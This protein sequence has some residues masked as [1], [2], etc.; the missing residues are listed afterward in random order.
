MLRKLVFAVLI[1][2]VGSITL[3]AVR[4]RG[5]TVERRAYS[6]PKLV[7]VIVIDQFRYDYL[8]RFRPEFV[9]G[10]F[11]RLLNGGANFI[12]CRYDDASTVTC[13]GH[14]ALFSGAY[15]DLNGIIANNWYD[16]VLHRSV[17]CATDLGT[18]LVGG[19]DVQ[20][21]VPAGA[22]PKNLMGT[23]LGDEMRMASDFKSKVV[24]ISLKDRSA[25]MPGGHTANAAYWYDAGSGHFV[26]STYYMPKLPAWVKTFN[27]HPPVASYCGKDWK[28]LPEN[29]IASGEVFKRFTPNQAERCPDTRFLNWL[30]QTPYM[31]ALEL[32]FAEDAI[33]N[34]HLGAGPATDL[35][36]ISISENDVIGHAYGPYSAQVAD[37]TLWTDR[38][39]AQFFQMVDQTVG[40]NNV[41]IVLSADHG[42][43][44]NPDFIVK[45]RL[46]QG[47]VDLADLHRE[48]ERALDARFGQDHWIESEDEFYLYLSRD[49]MAR[50]HVSAEAVEAAAASA[51]SQVDGV[52]AAFTRAQLMSSQVPP[53][54]LARKVLHSFNPQRSGDVFLVL[55][56]FSVAV[57]PG[58][59]TTHGTPWSYDAQVPLIFWGNAFTPGIY[60]TPAQPVDLAATVA[61]AL[62]ITQPSDE[63]GEPLSAAIR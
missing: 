54:A 33:R 23:T 20:A 49:A 17:Y 47:S 44:P 46:G 56:P 25:V 14:A 30:H 55:D 3:L 43:A 6:R 62:G 36:A 13:A 28:A 37:V 27:Q 57:P 31:T 63:E 9:T 60:W 45:H 51:A 42:V 11:T 59:R 1:V 61:A 35:L 32:D 52:R 8:V 16:P 39:L 53:T 4:G 18:K 50:H 29:P 2:A 48:V 38:Y 22:S 19:S 15:P 12:N 58:I 10:G 26:S 21:S 40:L 34:D 7:I 24:A 5:Q 41:W